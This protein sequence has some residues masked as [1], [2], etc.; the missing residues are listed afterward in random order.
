MQGSSGDTAFTFDGNTAALPKEECNPRQALEP[1]KVKLDQACRNGIRLVWAEDGER[2]PAPLHH[3]VDH[4]ALEIVKIE[5]HDEDQVPGPK[6]QDQSR[7]KA[8]AKATQSP[9]AKAAQRR[10]EGPEPEGNQPKRRRTKS[11]A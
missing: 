11:A 10:E 7:S 3:G 5:G 6:L 2:Q 1:V 4:I 9:A 8:K